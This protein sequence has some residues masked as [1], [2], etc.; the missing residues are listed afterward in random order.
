[1]QWI[2]SNW[3]VILLVAIAAMCLFGH[4]SKGHHTPDAC[5][6]Q[7]DKTRDKKKHCGHDCCH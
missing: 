7:D 1:M 6:E 5:T 2:M 3:Y 4:R